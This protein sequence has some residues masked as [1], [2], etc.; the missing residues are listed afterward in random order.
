MVTLS[1][2]VFELH[3]HS[4]AAVLYERL[5]PLAGQLYVLVG[6]I[7]CGGSYALWCGMLAACL[8]RWDDAERHFAEALAMNERLGA[9]PYIVRTRRAW[10]G[11]LLDRGTP[12]DAVHARDLIAAALDEAELLGMAREV[13]R[14]QRLQAR[15]D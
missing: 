2:A 8:G 15:L 1:E 9:R 4:A 7:N 3:D 13:V 6:L 10:A 11:M 14:L 5:H 12:D